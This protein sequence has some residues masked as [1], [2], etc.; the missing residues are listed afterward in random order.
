MKK[1]LLPALMGTGL[2]F[3]GLGNAFAYNDTYCAWVNGAQLTPQ[4][5]FYLEALYRV[6]LQC[7]HYYI[8]PS[9]T[10]MPASPG[11]RPSENNRE[12]NRRGPFGDYMS[13]GEC[14]FVNGIPVGKC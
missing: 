7:G 1:L 14:S 12:S 10:I 3:G 8:D 4:Q 13:D 5:I 6:N 9:G 11:Q 2:L